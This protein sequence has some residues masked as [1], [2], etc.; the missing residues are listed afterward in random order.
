MD[1]LFARMKTALGGAPDVVVYNP[2]ARARGPLV[3]LDR[4]AVADAL[5]VTAYGAFLT[6]QAAAREMLPQGKGAIL[7][8]GAS[9]GLKG[10]PL[11]APFAMGK[12][13]LRGLAE[14]LAR[15]LSP[16]GIHV[17]H[18]VVDGVIRNPGRQEPPD[19]PELAARP[20]RHRRDLRHAAGPGPLRLDPRD[21][22]AALGRDLLRGIEPAGPRRLAR[23]FSK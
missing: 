15:E 1:G 18:V 12:F 14:S 5:R 23:C 21:H 20:R 11:S 16:K 7:F 13:A 17:A 3:D 9:A 8:T 4:E 6:A 2:S 10:F 22:R 19:R